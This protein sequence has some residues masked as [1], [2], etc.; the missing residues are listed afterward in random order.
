MMK[1]KRAD[2]FTGTVL[3]VF[4]LLFAVYSAIPAF[5]SDSGFNEQEKVT[6]EAGQTA[7]TINH[8]DGRKDLADRAV[9]LDDRNTVRQ[10]KVT[11]IP[12][13]APASET[14]SSGARRDMPVVKAVIEEINNNSIPLLTPKTML[15]D[16]AILAQNPTP[17]EIEKAKAKAMQEYFNK[18]KVSVTPYWFFFNA[19]MD[20]EMGDRTASSTIS[21]DKLSSSLDGGFNCRLDI[22]KAHWGGFVDVSDLKFSKTNSAR[23]ISSSM[24]FE[25]RISHYCFY[26]RFSGVPVFDIYGGARTFQFDSSIR[27]Q[28]QRF[29]IGLVPAHTVSG[30]TSWTDPMIGARM[31]APLSKNFLVLVGGDCG[32]FSDTHNS[33]AVYGLLSWALSH[34]ISINGGYNLMG[35]EYRKSGALA[36]NIKLKC[37]LNGPMLSIGI[38]F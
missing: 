15:I 36:D 37:R 25:S 24:Q 19:N 22:N 30:S 14:K 20:I 27:L 31:V 35:F 23:F 29:P 13:T 3:A 4:L 6:S 32:G 33:Y 17:E 8:E 11:L 21:Y 10:L 9:T 16:S 26:Y 34:N 28:P 12:D 7:E 18:W 38:N 1:K 2:I 5:A